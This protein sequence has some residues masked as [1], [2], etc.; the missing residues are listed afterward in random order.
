M[1]DKRLYDPVRGPGAWEGA[2]LQDSDVWLTKVTDENIEDMEKAL[3]GVR[4]RGLSMT[5]ITRD[6]FALPSMAAKLEEIADDIENGRGFRL[7]RGLPVQ[8]WGVEDATVIYWG[9]STH[10][11]SP[12]SQSSQGT[13]MV[14]VRDTG[15]EAGIDVRGPQTA[16]RLYYHSDFSD[17]VGLMC[18]HPAKSGGISRICSS[19][20]VF[21]RLIEASRHDLV[22]AFYDGYLFDRKG[23]QGPNVAPISECP[24]PMLSWHDGRLSF[25]YT[26]GW[27]EAAM[28]RTGGRWSEVQQ[29]AID[30]VN[31]LT[32]LPELYLDMNFQAGDIQ[33]LNNYSV[34]HSRTEFTD[35]P[36]PERKR[37][38]QRIWLH[39][40]K[41]REL[42]FSFDHLFGEASTRDGIPKLAELTG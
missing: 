26:P 24:I 14:A 1:T 8:S 34:L 19:L 29:A 4:S 30:E 23:E 18:M 20:A 10:I 27:S 31:R 37:F 11:G 35:Y 28:R 39:A 21:N 13:M 25:R 42:A 22:D 12:V 33:Y 3:A 5:N 7:I 2:N 41:G 40:H 16:S 38:L 36:E 15:A 17:I 32:N 9:I 6:D